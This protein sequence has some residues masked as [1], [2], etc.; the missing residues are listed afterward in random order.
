MYLCLHVEMHVHTRLF[1]KGTVLFAFHISLQASPN[2]WCSLPAPGMYLSSVSKFPPIPMEPWLLPWLIT[3]IRKGV[4]LGF[5]WAKTVFIHPKLCSHLLI[6]CVTS[7]CLAASFQLPQE[8]FSGLFLL[9]PHILCFFSK[10][11]YFSFTAPIF[12]QAPLSFHSTQ[13]AWHT[14]G[15]LPPNFIW[16]SLWY[17]FFLTKTFKWKC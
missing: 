1:F 5:H 3:S 17:T 2:T 12:I 15:S 11:W 6:P 14:Y 4:V 9:N 10:C 7:S 16:E 13:C 8:A